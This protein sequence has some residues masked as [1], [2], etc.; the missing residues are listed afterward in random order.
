MFHRF[1]RS[2]EDINEYSAPLF[3]C[4]HPR[5]YFVIEM[6]GIVNFCDHARKCPESSMGNLKDMSLQDRITVVKQLL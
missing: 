4:I 1:E 6:D 3:E 2:S 5:R